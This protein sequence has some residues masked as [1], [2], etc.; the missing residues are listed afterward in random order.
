MLAEI[1]DEA[2]RT[3]RAAGADV[4]GGHSTEG[5]ELTIGFTVTGTAARVIPKGG[6]RPGDALILTKPLGSGTILAAEMAL[7]TVPGPLLMAEVWAA[8]IDQ[9]TRAQG[10]A[11]AIL[12]PHAHAMTDIT[13]FGLSGHLLELLDA[14]TAAATLWLEAIP[15]LPGAPELAAAGHGSS[16]LPANLAAVSWRMTGPQDPRIDLLSDPQTAGGL[17]AAVPPDQAEVLLAALKAAGHEA[18]IVG[19]VTAGQPHLTVTA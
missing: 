13:G 10:S 8:C 19:T 17:I 7:A 1:M 9:M 12:A 16:L 5:A 6:A 2:A 11:A 14:S 3:F 4:V 15:L 18:A